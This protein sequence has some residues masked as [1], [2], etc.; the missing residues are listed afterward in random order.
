MTADD[1]GGGSVLITG[2][3]G[4][5]GSHLVRRLVEQGA[6][7]TVVVRP[8][9]ITSGL[10]EGVERIVHDGTTT[11]L[12]EAVRRVRPAVA[13]HLAARYVGEHSPDDVVGLVQDNV[14]FSTQVFE[15]LASAECRGVVNAGTGWQHQTAAPD[16]PV[17]LYAATKQAVQAILAFYA[18][19]T[20]LRSVTLKLFDTYGPGDRRPKLFSVLRR[21]SEDGVPLQMS[22]GEQLVDLVYIDDV[23]T[24]FLVAAQRLTSSQAAPCESFSIPAARRFTLREVVEMYRAVVP[25]PPEVVWGGRPYRSREVMVPWSGEPL[26]GWRP[27]VAL[28]DGLR[29]LF[30]DG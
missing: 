6:K 5:I 12:V 21:A 7:V 10:P 11:G 3:T 18:G 16:C 28:A 13:F 1:G 14:T 15:A 8:G 23:V 26:P 4:F 27:E 20:S 9:S 24:A 30:A 25:R 19:A 17:N 22:K 29:S 2:A